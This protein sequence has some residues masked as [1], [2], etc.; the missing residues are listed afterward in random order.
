M[1][2]RELDTLEQSK[3]RRWSLKQTVINSQIGKLAN[4]YSLR[5]VIFGVNQNVSSIPKDWIFPTIRGG[6]A[7][8]LGH[9]M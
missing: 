4:Y 3:S 8:L 1:Y 5:K 2:K 9:I 7:C 6:I